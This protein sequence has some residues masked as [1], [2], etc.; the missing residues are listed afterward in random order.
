M[1]GNPGV[2]PG[3][4]WSQARRVAVSLASGGEG[5]NR[6]GSTTLA[7]RVRYLTCHPHAWT[8][9]DLNRN[10]RPAEAALCQLELAA[11][12][13]RA[14][15]RWRDRAGAAARTSF[16]LERTNPSATLRKDQKNKVRW[17]ARLACRY[18]AHAMEFSINMPTMR[19]AGTAGIEPAHAALETAVLPLNYVPKGGEGKEKPP[20]RCP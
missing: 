11:Q 7:G 14:L 19:R 8:A 12:G 18:G 5:R 10:L 3:V 16:F 4:S 17:Q 15:I 1:I 9:P 6:T 2:E 13:R 20:V